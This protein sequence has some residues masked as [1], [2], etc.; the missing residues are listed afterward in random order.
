MKLTKKP[1]NKTQSFIEINDIQWGILPNKILRFFSITDNTI[2]ENTTEN[3]LEELEKYAYSKAISYLASRERSE[4]EV[5]RYLQQHKFHPDIRTKIIN[6]LK[7][8][9]YLNNE[10]FAE[11][12]T[13]DLIQ[14]KK[15]RREIYHKLREKGIDKNQIEKSLNNF[16]TEDEQTQ[17]L[18]ELVKKAQVKYRNH[19]KKKEK[20]ITYLYRKGFKYDEI[21]N[22]INDEL[23]E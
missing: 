11:L 14:K 16:Y 3:L 13:A 19:P 23:E 6:K 18:Q 2:D 17:I 7:S 9:N 10:R 5:E 1:K 22:N 12:Y 21:V 15:S 4:R 20:I 8:Q